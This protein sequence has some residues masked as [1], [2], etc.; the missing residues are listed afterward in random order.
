[1]RKMKNWVI[2]DVDFVQFNEKINSAFLKACTFNGSR[3]W[4]NC[5]DSRHMV[6][7]ILDIRKGSPTEGKIICMICQLYRV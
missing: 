5:F 2:K 1:M 6:D 4:V 3:R 7:M